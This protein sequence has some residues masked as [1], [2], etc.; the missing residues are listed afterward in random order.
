MVYEQ[1]VPTGNLLLIFGVTIAFIMEQKDL[2]TVPLVMSTVHEF[3]SVMKFST[4]LFAQ[5]ICSLAF[6]ITINHAPTTLRM[7]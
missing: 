5:H 3:H 2:S 4:H 1:K 6:S 7:Y